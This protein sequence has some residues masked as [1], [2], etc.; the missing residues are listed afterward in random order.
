MKKA[1]IGPP[2]LTP[3]R[4]NDLCA[5]ALNIFNIGQKLH[6]NKLN[7]NIIEALDLLAHIIR[8]AHAACACGRNHAALDLARGQCGWLRIGSGIQSRIQERV[9]TAAGDVAST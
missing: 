8:C 9:W 2:F 7:A 4:L 6:Q 3:Q 5:K 1:A